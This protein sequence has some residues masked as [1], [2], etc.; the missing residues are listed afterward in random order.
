[1]NKGIGTHLLQN[2]AFWRLSKLLVRTIGLWESFVLTDIIDKRDYHSRK[3]M[4][5]NEWFFYTRDE[6]KKQ[7]GISDTFQRTLLNKLKDLGFI[8]MKTEGMPRRT[9][10]KI[11]DN[12]IDNYLKQKLNEQD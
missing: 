1:M 9:Y 7:L 8:D 4:L 3:N 2:S 12:V 6:M 10:Y 11:N 5:D